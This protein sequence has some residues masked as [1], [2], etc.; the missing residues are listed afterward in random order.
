MR[1]N[2]WTADKNSKVFCSR[3]GP[4]SCP[5]IA[6]FDTEAQLGQ[7][8]AWKPSLTAAVRG[9]SLD[10][11]HYDLNQWPQWKRVWVTGVSGS[12]ILWACLGQAVDWHSKEELIN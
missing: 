12:L 9:G 10:L 5:H 11:K 7:G 3:L 2:P 6:S 1:D 8:R 4:L